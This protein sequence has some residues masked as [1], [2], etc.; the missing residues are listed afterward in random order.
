[1]KPL[2]SLRLRTE[3]PLVP[4][5]HRSCTLPL[6][7]SSSAP[8]IFLFL[9]KPLH[10]VSP[11][12]SPALLPAS[13]LK[14]QSVMAEWHCLSNFTGLWLSRFGLSESFPHLNLLYLRL[15]NI[16]LLKPH[17]L[18]RTGVLALVSSVFFSV[19]VKIPLPKSHCFGDYIQKASLSL[20]SLSLDSALHL[21]ESCHF[22]AV[23]HLIQ[24][25]QYDTLI[26]V[27]YYIGK[28]T[29]QFCARFAFIIYLYSPKCPLTSA[30]CTALQTTRPVLWKMLRAKDPRLCQS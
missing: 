7:G 3:V 27:R 15:W 2:S 1:M 11:F 17:C 25:D 26:C 24:W 5:C 28:K 29:G 19:I 8:I 21:V 12:F 22:L 20:S 6:S 16:Y 10:S 18:F 9:C 14:E 4:L 13:T 23:C 30:G